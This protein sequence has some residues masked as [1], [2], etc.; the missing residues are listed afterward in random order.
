MW[1]PNSLKA[2]E[3]EVRRYDTGFSEY[4]NN[5]WN[6]RIKYIRRLKASHSF[7]CTHIFE[8][9]WQFIN[10][11]SF[12]GKC[13]KVVLFTWDISLAA[14]SSSMCHE[15]VTRN[16]QP[17]FNPL[18]KHDK[19]SKHKLGGWCKVQDK[20]WNYSA[21]RNTFDKRFLK[22]AT[23]LAISFICS[24]QWNREIWTEVVK[25]TPN[26]VGKFRWFGNYF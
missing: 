1:G 10:I 21:F 16:H 19:N 3:G 11:K 15:C 20:R 23:N 25:F 24:C 13:R 26:F 6:S 9:M 4:L 5:S 22:F 14:E 12:R 18:F 2:S 17:S 8:R 7:C